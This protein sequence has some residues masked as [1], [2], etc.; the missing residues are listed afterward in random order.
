M[1]VVIDSSIAACWGLPDENSPAAARALTTTFNEDMVVPGLFWH[2]LRNVFLV[3]ERRRLLTTDETETGLRLVENMSPRIDE[4]ASH[5]DVLEVARRHSLS[6]YDA[7]YLELA[8]R[9]AAALA[10]LDARLARAAVAEGVP[11]ITEPD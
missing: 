4:T 5:Q 3:N 10:T 1:A 2:E 6:A 8:K 7:T 11:V 9:A